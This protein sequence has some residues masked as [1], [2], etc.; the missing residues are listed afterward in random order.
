MKIA[1]YCANKHLPEIDFSEP[2][3][4]NPGCG[5]AEY[6]HIAIPFMLDNFYSKLMKTVIIADE[7]D[8][9]PPNIESYKVNHGV[10]EAASLAKSIECDVFVFRPRMQEEDNILSHLE[11]IQLKSVGRAALTPNYDH[12]IK[13]GKSNYFKALICVGKNQFNHLIDSPVSKKIVQINNCIS[14]K[15][16]GQITNKPIFDKRKDVVFM[17]SLMPQKNFHYLA[18]VWNQISKKIPEANLHV[19]G[20]SKTYGIKENL[21][22]FGLAEEK[23]E[24]YFMSLLNKDRISAKKVFFHGNLSFEKYKILSNAK[25]GVVNPLGTTETCCVSAVE[26]QAMGIPVCTGNYESLRTTVINKRSGL[27]SKNKKQFIKNIVSVYKNKRIFN[28]LSEG[29]II[30]A[31]I[32]FSFSHNINKWYSLFYKINNNIN[33]EANFFK[34]IFDVKSILQLLIV[35]NTIFFR[36]TLGIRTFS[37]LKL[38]DLL[39]KIKIFLKKIILNN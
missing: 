29:A 34:S 15:L 39:K 38:I 31:K 37:L 24:K 16:I 27:L 36:K 2:Y 11:S 8:K 23:Y 30:N 7:V 22:K 10:V 26:M 18:S 3:S 14:D 12:L 25:V 20:S 35:I 9:L 6:L 4:G 17:G 28:K 5:A 1:F 13:M 33:F 21:G 32:N 19:I